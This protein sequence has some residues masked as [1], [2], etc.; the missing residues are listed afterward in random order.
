MTL[1]EIQAL[2]AQEKP[3]IIYATDE[4]K[5]YIIPAGMSGTSALPIGSAEL[6]QALIAAAIIDKEAFRTVIEL[7]IYYQQ[8]VPA[9]Y[10]APPASGNVVLNVS[11]GLYQKAAVTGDIDSLTVNGGSINTMFRLWLTP[12]GAD[13]LLTFDAI[14]PS[15]SGLVLPKVLTADKLYVI[16]LVH[17]GTAWMLISL[18]GGY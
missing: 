12:S 17:N 15:D 10:T 5:H 8:K 2:G 9:I 11:N 4:E 18:V 1:A 6:T 3:R 14:I 16:Q 7:P 13:R